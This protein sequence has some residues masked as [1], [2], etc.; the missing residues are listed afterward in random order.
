MPQTVEAI[1]H[2]QA[3]GVPM[4]FAINKID[5]PGANPE[6]IR[7]QLSQIHNTLLSFFELKPCKYVSVYAYFYNK[8]YVTA[9]PA[10]RYVLL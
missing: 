9:I 10:I 4:V 7:E 6:K 1:N 8:Q 2:A 3:A 5:K